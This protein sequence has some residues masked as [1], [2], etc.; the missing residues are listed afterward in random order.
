MSQIYLHMGGGDAGGGGG[1][2]KLS[3]NLRRFT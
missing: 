2:A 1:G 3:K